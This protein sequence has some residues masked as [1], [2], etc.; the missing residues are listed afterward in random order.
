MTFPELDD[1]EICEMEVDLFNL[2]DQTIKIRYEDYI[3]QNQINEDVLSRLQ[4]ERDESPMDDGSLSGRASS[5]DEVR[6]G[7]KENMSSALLNSVSTMDTSDDDE[8]IPLFFTCEKCDRVFFAKSQVDSHENQCTGEVLDG[9]IFNNPEDIAEFYEEHQTG[10]E[11]KSDYVLFYRPSVTAT[12]ETTGRTISPEDSEARGGNRKDAPQNL[13]DDFMSSK[14][15]RSSSSSKKKA[16]RK[17]QSETEFE[18]DPR[19]TRQDCLTM[20]NIEQLSSTKID[21]GTGLPRQTITTICGDTGKM[22]LVPF[23]HLV[24]IFIL[25]SPVL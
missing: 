24:F 10:G 9:K 1:T 13:F 23:L 19:H 7:D 18:I 14:S 16:K 25:I 8:Q 20:N 6:I 21:P 5:P 15:S 11:L 4:M 3:E 17:K 22:V 2:L 12:N